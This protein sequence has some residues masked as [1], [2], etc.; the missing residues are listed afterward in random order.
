MSKKSNSNA[1]AETRTRVVAVAGHGLFSPALNHIAQ[2]MRFGEVSHPKGPI[3]TIFRQNL[4]ITRGECRTAG[5]PCGCLEQGDSERRS[6]S[7][8]YL[9]VE[10]SCRGP[11][12][13]VSHVLGAKVAA[14][15]VSNPNPKGRPVQSRQKKEPRATKK[16]TH[17][18]G[19][20]W[21][22]QKKQLKCARRDSNP[23]RGRSRGR[24][25]FARPKPHHPTMELGE[26][27]HSKVSYLYQKVRI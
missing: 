1:H 14:L 26:V 9:R 16:R 27:E 18:S 6:P 17:C 10:G 25:F 11:Q 22:E 8:R 15:K 4:P 2:T 20:G 3:Y 13:P 19:P 7:F 21:R 12:R 24:P 23:G 5:A